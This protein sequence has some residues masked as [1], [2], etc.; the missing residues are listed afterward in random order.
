MSSRPNTSET[1][2]L[3]IELLRRIPR[4]HKVTA[5]ELHLQLSDIGIDRSIRT[6]Q[7]QLDSLS[8]HFDIE[9]D[10]RNKPYGYRWKEQSNG[11]SLPILS[12]Q[13]TLLLA[14]AEDHLSKFL[15]ASLT[16]SMDGFFRQ[17]RYNLATKNEKQL[18]REWLSKV[19]VV[20]TTQ[21]LLP[22]VMREGIL[23]EISNAL[24]ANQWL[25]VTYEDRFEELKEDKEIMP[26][27]L[28]QQGPRLYLVCRFK[29]YDNERSLAIHRI[30]TAKAITKTFDRPKD[31]D[32]EEYDNNGQFGFGEGKMIKLSFKI[33]PSAGA[34]LKE[35]PLS[36]DQTIEEL[37]NNWL[38]ITATVVDTAQ[39]DWWLR[40]FGDGVSA[41]SKKLTLTK[42]EGKKYDNR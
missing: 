14:L 38:Y 20:S 24:Y 37:E 34:H 42:V 6:I 18:E 33:S 22:P 39:L 13:E 36:T 41:V 28:A 12:K 10:D 21:P 11:L 8:E 32:L 26:L 23:E 9:R 5:N 40:G 30:H 19:R 7:R 35:T 31:F 29:G 17:A 1:V 25:R 27:G 3:A 4:N 2:I 16:K 15:P